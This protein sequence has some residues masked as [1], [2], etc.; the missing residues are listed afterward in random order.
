[1][2]FI[3]Y[4]QTRNRSSFY[5]TLFWVSTF[6]SLICSA[7]LQHGNLP[8]ILALASGIPSICFLI[9]VITSFTKLTFNL[10]RYLALS[11]SSVLLAYV[12]DRLSMPFEISCLPVAL[13]VGLPSIIYGYKIYIEYR[14]ESYLHLTLAL[15]LM[16]HGAHLLDYPF[17]RMNPIH[18][19]WGFI[20]YFTII[21]ALSMLSPAITILTQDRIRNKQLKKEVESKTAELQQTIEM[22]DITYQVLVHD[23]A[24]YLFAIIA[25]IRVLNRSGLTAHQQEIIDKDTEVLNK[26]KSLITEVRNLE[27]ALNANDQGT[28]SFEYNNFKEMIKGLTETYA[29]KLESKNIAIIDETLDNLEILTYE[30]FFSTSIIGNYLSNAIKFSQENMNIVIATEV[31]EDG[32]LFIRIIDRGIGIPEEDLQKMNASS[33][34]EKRQGTHKEKGTG[35]GTLIA[36]NY[37]KLHNL[38]VHFDSITANKDNNQVGETTITI[39][40]SPSQYRIN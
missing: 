20:L 21:Q 1:M 10:K 29:T 4:L 11:L 25:S 12:L 28:I 15:F 8:I 24:N 5:Q 38:K 34:P 30:P 23:F 18:Q 33:T 13:A 22:K 27:R 14:R 39:T 2:Q 16:A 6:F 9:I 40:F 3:F 37:L 35:L 17:L 31:S 32:L 7:S 36:S 19:T 26:M